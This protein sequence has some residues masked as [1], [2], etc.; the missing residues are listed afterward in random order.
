MLLWR[1]S[2]SGSPWR[3]VTGDQ[4][5]A[6]ITVWRRARS[7]EGRALLP[8]FST[9][10]RRSL[11]IVVGTIPDKLVISNGLHLISTMFRIHLFRW[12]SWTRWPPRQTTLQ[13][14]CITTYSVLPTIS[15]TSIF[16][17]SA[18]P[19]YLKHCAT[20]FKWQTLLARTDRYQKVTRKSY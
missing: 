12:Q 16:I 14:T 5:Q 4:D 13:M 11:Y 15:V 19:G 1:Q 20:K 18:S 8:E 17:Y 3:V 7:W 9:E 2:A 6:A 10:A